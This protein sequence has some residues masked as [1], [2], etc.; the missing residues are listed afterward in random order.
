[1]AA[2]GPCATLVTDLASQ[3]WT[4]LPDFLRTDAVAALRDEAE[5]LWAA[6]RFREA[7][8]GRAAGY[9]VREDLRGDRIFW[10]DGDGAPQAQ[11]RFRPEI[12]RLRLD[13]NREL[14]L[15]LV[16][17]EGHYAVYPPG[18][19][20]EAHRDRFG[21]SDERAI[22]CTLYLNSGWTARHG[23][24]LRLHAAGR[25]LDIQPRGGTLVLFRSDTVLHEVLP[26]TRPRFSLTGWLRR[27]PLRPALLSCL[28]AVL[29]LAG[30]PRAARAAERP[31][32]PQ[33]TVVLLHGLSRTPRSMRRLETALAR[34]GY[35]VVSVNY[36]A[37]RKPI[38][39][40]A[41]VL[42]ARRADRRGAG[43]ARV[44]FVTH[45]Y[46]GIVL[47]Y[48]LETRPFPNLGRVVMLCP[49]SAGSELADLLRRIPVVRDVAG[50]VRLTLGTG[51]GSLPAC[52]GPVHFELG[53]IAGNRSL[54]PLFSWIIPGPDDGMVSVE[55]AKVPGMSDFLVV[56]R[57]H[58]FIMRSR[59]VIAQTETFL[60]TGRFDHAWSPGGVRP[61]GDIQGGRRG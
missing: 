48:Y 2:T 31:M 17:F 51:P 38:G 28:L 33:E 43:R 10:L 4:V 5:N 45:S 30:A 56:P 61:T 32:S 23:G 49:P 50:P 40:I 12:E 34:S 15:G 25:H 22:S 42:D 11:G 53:I 21:T 37:G 59:E 3:G 58:T 6:G 18:A 47:R 20:Y 57:T 7:G 1:M 35:R 60:Q 46:G 52:L 13:L 29:L 19:R 27:R 44:D 26:A 8:V 16:S 39:A 9:A 36:P 24:E 14:F 55:R 41:D 54:N